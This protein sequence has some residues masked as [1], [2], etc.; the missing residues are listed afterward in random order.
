MTEEEKT[1]I[2]DKL[3]QEYYQSDYKDI[4]WKRQEA[5]DQ[6]Y[7]AKYEAQC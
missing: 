6:I 4:C 7:Q 2:K 3:A 1:K 5:I